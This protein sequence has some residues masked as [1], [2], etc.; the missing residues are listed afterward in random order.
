MQIS[1]S[2]KRLYLSRQSR[3]IVFCLFWLAGFLLGMV[4]VAGLDGSLFSLM[5]PAFGGW[6]SIIRQ[7][8]A[9]ILP[10]L[11][12]AFAAYSNKP[13]FVQ[14]LCLLKACGFTFC[15]MAINSAYGSAAWLVRFLLQFSDTLTLPI[16]CWFCLQILRKKCVVLNDLIICIVFAAIF[17][18]IEHFAV[19]PFLAELID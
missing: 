13:F 2:H 11:F 19:L 4:L 15:G 6:V 8:A 10:F 5:R 17:V 14:F 7:F 9:L 16:F 1:F 3:Y 18:C 12:A